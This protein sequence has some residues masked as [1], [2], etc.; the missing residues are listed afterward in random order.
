MAKKRK[1]RPKTARRNPPTPQGEALPSAGGA[2]TATAATVDAAPRKRA[3]KV[4]ATPGFDAFWLVL[5]LVGAGVL[6]TAYL[7][8]THFTDSELAACSAGSS[9]DLVQQ[10]RWSTFLR[11]PL[12]VWGLL[13][14]AV[15]GGI[16]WHTRKRPERWTMAMYVALVGVAISGYLQAVS[17]FEIEAM[18]PY[19]VASAGLMTVLFVVL[20]IFRPARQRN[21]RWAAFGPSGA[22]FAGLVVLFLHLHYNGTFDAGAGPEKPYLKDLAIHLDDTGARFYGAYWCPHCQQQKALFE[23]SV[24]RLPYVECSPGGRGTPMSAA[25]VANNI[26]DFP[27]WIVDG[28]RHPGVQTPQRLAQLSGFKGKE[29]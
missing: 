9:C 29:D 10:S 26:R 14:Y 13:T 20:A 8:L 28:R 12:A 21:F 5:G 23:A 3:A 27:T 6:L 1:N 2:A 15:I 16:V 25:C 7:S 4:E 22:I 18:C 19:C 11:L 24:D 17:Y